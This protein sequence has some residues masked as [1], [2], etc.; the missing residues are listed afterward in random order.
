MADDKKIRINYFAR[1]KQEGKKIA[2]ITAYDYSFALIVDNAGIEMVIVGDSAGMVIAGYESTLPV[3]MDEIIYHLKAVKRGVE[4]AFIVADMPFLSYQISLEEAKRN[5]GKLLQAGAEAVKLEGGE[6]FAE[7]IEALVKAGIPV[8]G[9]LGL[10]P[11][12]VNV[13]GGYRVQGKDKK[14]SEGLMQSAKVI[15]Q[16]GVFSTVLE[17]VPAK[18]GGRISRELKIPTIGI[19]AGAGCNGQVLVLYDLLGIR[20]SCC[21]PKFVKAYAPVGEIALLAIKEYIEEVKDKKFP[22]KENEY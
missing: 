19:G 7:T 1:M 18:L 4:R 21:P 11:Q 13:L 10:T 8:M 6:V 22:A 16:A 2:V 14:S 3:T 9:H 15:E 5:A 12:S 20:G 17:G